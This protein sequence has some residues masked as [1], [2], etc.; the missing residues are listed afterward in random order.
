MAA[1]YQS[2]M[3]LVETVGRIAGEYATY[4][5]LQLVTE[6]CCNEYCTAHTFLMMWFLYHPFMFFLKIHVVQFQ[7]ITQAMVYRLGP[8]QT[9]AHSFMCQTRFS[10]LW[11]API[12]FFWDKKCSTI[13]AGGLQKIILCIP[14]CVHCR[15]YLI[16]NSDSLIMFLMLWY[17]FNGMSF[18]S[19]I[20][21]Y[22]SI[23]ATI[24]S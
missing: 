18:F 5:M 15:P 4:N 2:E 7:N 17:L 19:S 23:F 20:F 21:E 14:Q 11:N 9:S 1:P 22:R 3:L 8:Y 24:R 6:A 16:L 12:T 10:H 13:L